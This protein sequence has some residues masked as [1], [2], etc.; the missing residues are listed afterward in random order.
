MLF[1]NSDEKRFVLGYDL[2]DKVSQISFLASDADMPETLSV[3]AGAELYNIPTVLCKRKD[4]NQWYYGKEALRQIDEGKA[5][6]VCNLVSAA[7]EGKSVMVGDSEYDPIALLTLFVKRSL[8]LLS[9][10][11]A[12]DKVEAIMFTTKSLD[13]RMVQVLNAVTASLELKT[14]NIFY[15]SHEESFYNYMLYQPEELMH[16][17]IIACDYD[18]ENLYVYEMSLNPNTTPIVATITPS[19]YDAL[20]VGNDGFPKDAALFHKTCERLDDEFLNIM[21]KVCGEK[22]VSTVFLLGD[23]YKEKWPKRSLEFL[24]RTRRVFQGNNLF[25]K[26]ATIAAR[27]RIR[28][29]EDAQKYVFLGEDKL[30]SNI[31]INLLKC[32]KE[33]YHAILDAGINWYEAQA[34][35][36]IYVDQTGV[37][38]FQITPLTGGKPRTIQLFLEDLEKRPRGTTRLQV[39][40]TMNAVDEVYIRVQDLGFG[41][42]FPATNQVWEQVIDL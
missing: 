32:G 42:I 35:L 31:G 1:G 10:E 17:E 7:R 36:D 9:M 30:K 34:Q 39:N 4:A 19:S 11:L 25:S 33:A 3:L 29:S 13:H 38:D 20:R 18:L 26:G 40:M 2:G 22:I 8:S 28:P 5:D 15:Q 23:G 14:T 41:E 27:E 16:H 24:C 12:L 37:L 21:Q 6:A